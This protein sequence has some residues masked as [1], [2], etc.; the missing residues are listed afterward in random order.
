MRYKRRPTSLSERAM[1]VHLRISMW[2]AAAK[3]EHIGEDVCKRNKSERDGG[4]WKTKL[5]PPKALAKVNQARMRCRHVYFKY[6]LPWMDGSLRIISSDM[7][8]SYMNAI[9][10]PIREYEKEV[11]AFLKTY[12]SIVKNAPERLGHLLDGKSL[13]TVNDLR[14]KFAVVHDVLALSDE[15]DFRVRLAAEDVKDVKERIHNSIARMSERAMTDLWEQMQKLVAKIAETLKEPD[16]IFRDSLIQN[17]QEFC[18]MVPKLNIEGSK[19]LEEM[20]LTVMQTLGKLIPDTLRKE[21]KKRKEACGEAR[22][23]MGKL[24]TILAMRNK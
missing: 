4:E 3:D 11:E 19:S 14:R 15:N 21:P 7:Y 9:R 17:L 23:L 1:L 5:I 24:D 22:K 8:V 2:T 18:A 10:K 13:P 12:P 6:T 16:K 20:R